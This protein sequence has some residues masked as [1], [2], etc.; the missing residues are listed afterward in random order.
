MLRIRAFVSKGK[1]EVVPETLVETQTRARSR[2]KVRGRVRG[3]EQTR[4]RA[5]GAA[6]IRGRSREVSPKPQVK[7]AED[8]VSPGF[9]APLFEETLLRMLE[10][11]ENFPQAGVAGTPHGSQTGF[12]EQ[13]TGQQ[14][15]GS[16][17]YQ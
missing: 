1:R 7:V 6:P 10:V 2:A 11:L 14:A 9:G 8:Q 3:V 17:S 4:G 15:L 13:I 16:V 5:R 12:G